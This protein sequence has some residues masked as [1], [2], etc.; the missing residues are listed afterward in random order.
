MSYK[1][2]KK[3]SFKTF[4]KGV[5]FDVTPTGKIDS[6]FSVTYVTLSNGRDPSEINKVIEVNPGYCVLYLL[7]KGEIS[8]IFYEDTKKEVTLTEKEYMYIT[9]G[10]KYEISGTGELALVMI[11]AYSD[12]TFSHPQKP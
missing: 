6:A 5:G 9:P 2:A 3:D 8:F 4:N 1:I 10:T 7:Q 12:K 11:P